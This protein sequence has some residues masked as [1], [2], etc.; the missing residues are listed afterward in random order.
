MI[1]LERGYRSDE[2]LALGFGCVGRGTTLACE[3]FDDRIVNVCGNAVV[4]E[5]RSPGDGCLSC[6]RQ[7][8]RRVHLDQRSDRRRY[9]RVPHSLLAVIIL[10]RRHGGR[11]IRRVEGDVVLR[12][13]IEAPR[14]IMLDSG[15]SATGTLIENNVV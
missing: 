12:Q 14:R 5:V 1:D 6:W 13:L 4:K 3:N 7:R 8:R 10:N 15:Y 2:L 11:Y 9:L